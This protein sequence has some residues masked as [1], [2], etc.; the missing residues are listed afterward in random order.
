MINITEADISKKERAHI[1][2][3]QQDEPDFVNDSLEVF[4]Y[5][6]ENSQPPLDSDNI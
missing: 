1:Q 3:K 5:G 2:H 4:W 6:A